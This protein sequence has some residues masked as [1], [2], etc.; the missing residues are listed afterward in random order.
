MTTIHRG[1]PASHLTE[2]IGR[3]A[4]FAR[5]RDLVG[6][7]RLITITGCAGVGKSRIALRLAELLRRSFSGAVCFIGVAGVMPEGV[8]PAILAG[9]GSTET[10]I[11]D[12]ARAIGDRPLLVVIDDLDCAPEAAEVIEELLRLTSETRI[13]VTSRQRTWIRGETTYVL[14][15]L[16]A[17][18]WGGGAPGLDLLLRR[19]E[20]E[21][22]GFA[23]PAETHAELVEI[24]RATEGVPRLVEAA[25]RMLSVVGVPA[26][27]RAIRDDLAV[28]DAF[29]PTSQPAKST[30]EAFEN[31]IARVS[32]E[33]RAL[34][35]R[36]ALFEGG[37]DLEF[38]A[39]L[40]AE[41]RLAAIVPL[42]GELAGASLILSTTHGRLRLVRVPAMY[43]RCAVAALAVEDRAA[44]VRRIERGLIDRLRRCGEQWFSE[45][46][47]ASIRFLNAH[48]ADV[49]A[50]LGSMAVDPARARTALD[51]IS[52]LRFYWQLHPVDAWPRAREWIEAGLAADP[53]ID[54]IRLRALQTDAYIAFHEGDVE[55]VHTRLADSR[56]ILGMVGSGPPERLLDRFLEAI[57]LLTDGGVD[58]AAERFAAVIEES[59]QLGLVEH[60]GE[61]Y[62]YLAAA[63]VSQGR[64]A[65]A[66]ATLDLAVEH[67]DL[68]G[69]VWGRAYAWW[70]RA[71]LA[72]RAGRRD[73]A[74]LGLRDAAQTMAEF[75]DR[76][77]VAFCRELLASA[78]GAASDAVA[79]RIEELAPVT[80][81]SGQR[82]PIPEFGPGSVLALVESP[83][84][85]IDPLAFADILDR[86]LGGTRSAGTSAGTGAPGV[87]SAREWEVASLVAEGLA[88]PAIAARLVL[89]RRTIEGHVQR[90]LAKLGFRSRSQI[91]VWVARH[92]GE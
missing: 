84:P 68:V 4:E 25:A 27:L 3:E 10:T 70:L 66:E 13:V 37:C 29:I 71:L 55:A 5:L 15:P 12:A 36:L 76:S 9:L 26:T 60:L 92:S 44:D 58:A 21:D 42:V 50:L 72:F 79:S 82:I 88:N 43:R 78:L 41:R 28:L 89:S 83:W 40:F 18:D 20:E 77:G 47:L 1:L 80:G 19:I 38:A 45:D 17:P 46:H 87:L 48:A 57:A 7:R 69:D 53:T 86:I 22:P 39:E 51:I 49:T 90:I 56:A 61:R 67:C 14:A 73:E 33:A 34:L 32:P 63:Q 2:F 30:R 6:A 59:K 24:A 75:G 85:T 65:E 74:V 81:A 52:A 31:A 23:A 64:E 8:G 35:G 16:P 11:A 54:V 91:A 62:W